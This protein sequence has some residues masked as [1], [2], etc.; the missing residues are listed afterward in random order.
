MID[1]LNHKLYSNY[2]VKK[3]VI[4][5]QI[6]IG[7]FAKLTGLSRQTLIFY[8]KQGILSP[9]YIDSHNNYRYYTREQIEWA[10]AITVLRECGLPLNEIKQLNHQ[11]NPKLM[12][13][14]FKQLEGNLHAKINHLKQLSSLLNYRQ[15]VTKEAMRIPHYPFTKI[16]VEPPVS[17]VKSPVITKDDDL[18][19]AFQQ[20]IKQCNQEGLPAGIPISMAIAQTDLLPLIFQKSYHSYFFYRSNSNYSAPATIPGG[21][22]LLLYCHASYHNP[23]P[24]YQLLHSFLKENSY[25]LNGDI[26]QDFLIDEVNSS[27][28]QNYILRLTIP[29]KSK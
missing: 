7:E 26:Y 11:R 9:D 25:H 28:R 21:K 27:N 4:M 2:T 8:D 22:H 10:S 14:M 18:W 23:L 29:I 12:L 24:A 6:K 17:I 5:Q 1:Y 19:T 20:F 16:V 15:Q 3:V 13:N